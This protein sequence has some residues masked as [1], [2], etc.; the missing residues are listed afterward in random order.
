[1]D[2]YSDSFIKFIYG[3]NLYF[4][5]RK[6]LGLFFAISLFFILF[7]NF[8][9]GFAFA[10]GV[11]CE[12]FIDTSNNTYRV[13]MNELLV[14]GLLIIFGIYIANLVST[15]PI[16]SWLVIT[17][18]VFAYSMLAV[19]GKVGSLICFSALLATLTTY[20]RSYPIDSA[21]EYTLIGAAG[22]LLYFA[23]SAFF[24][25]IFIQHERRQ[26]MATALY[27]TANYIHF[28]AN[29][30]D[31]NKNLDDTYK[32]LIPR[33]SKMVE[34][35]GIA[36][37]MVLRIFGQANEKN[38][39]RIRL[40][41]IY[42]EMDSILDSMVSTQTDYAYLHERLG[43]HDAMLF[44]RDTL[45]KLAQTL[46]HAATDLLRHRPL[47]Y[48]N[49]VKAELRA[50]EFEIETFRQERL[51]D[52]DPDLYGLMI[53][54]L[55]RLRHANFCV[56]TISDN[57]RADQT[58]EFKSTYNRDKSLLHLRTSQ[59][60]KISTLFKNLNP[61][62][63][64]F[65]YAV[66]ISTLVFLVLI[67]NSVVALIPINKE[68]HENLLGHAN[69]ILFTIIL[70]MRSGFATTSQRSSWRLVGTLIGCLLTL[71]FLLLTRNTVVIFIFF[72]I[73]IILSNTFSP[74]NLR[75]GSIF[76][77][78]Y[79]LIG[80]YFITPDFYWVV[81]QR[82]IDTIVA[83]ILCYIFSFV[84]PRWEKDLIPNLTQKAVD[85]V[86]AYLYY[87]LR[88]SESIH[89]P[90]GALSPQE[91]KAHADNQ[92]YVNLQVARKDMQSSYRA[93]TE[94]FSRMM[95]EP[96]R[97]QLDVVSLNNIQIQLDAMANQISA[98]IPI[99]ESYEVIP[100]SI[101][102]N[103]N[104]IQS[105]L[106][107]KAE[108]RKDPIADIS[109]ENINLRFPIKQ[110]FISASQ[111]QQELLKLDFAKPKEIAHEAS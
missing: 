87:A 50:L 109:N 77:T 37:E 15:F 89:N 96:K 60:Y 108:Q 59:R 54:V 64:A 76:T 38:Q 100:E 5:L 46:D 66:R 3:P 95:N 92:E 75:L 68:L 41:N 42:V 74:T 72:F 40:W 73:C 78:A 16:W 4:G 63:S 81:G 79:V 49:S 52:T 58:L 19:Y 26:I 21:L 90:T 8:E 24:G 39:K 67:F 62:S 84:L 99:L 98:T 70:I 30:F 101:Y 51:P 105:I 20:T 44:M 102:N 91:L 11:L 83:S 14:G 106:E 110:M 43:N 57:L 13:R 85:C 97:Q 17:L 33:L 61:Q 1:M 71:G 25:F 103:L 111:I 34:S 82:L 29:L 35:Q 80:F 47:S 48:R 107:G 93:F 23:Y 69:W 9:V 55:R 86:T 10:T 104:Y 65:R 28:R 36:R 94:S 6:G 18:L 32:K 12:S 7:P 45:K 31:I 56:N 27:D 22:V 53:K 88:Y 2:S